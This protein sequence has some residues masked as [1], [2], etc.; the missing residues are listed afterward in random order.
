VAAVGA[1]D[2]EVRYVDVHAQP[3]VTSLRQLDAGRVV[4]GRP[5]RKIPSPAGQRHYSGLFWSATTGGHVPYES[6]LELDRLLL[7]DFDATVVWMAAQPLWLSGRDGSVLRRHVPDLLLEHRDGSLVLVD[8]KPPEL[9]ARPA[10]AGVFDWT[11]ALCAAKGWRYEVWCGAPQV[12]LANVRWLS[13]ARRPLAVDP[14]TREVLHRVGRSGMTVNEVVAVASQR[15][16]GAIP[17]AGVLSL[18]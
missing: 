2:V 4:R 14:R 17:L 12:L 6:R 18:P 16:D 10:V 15:V 7:A 5:V 13:S 11:A 1:L 8:V 9:A 3:V